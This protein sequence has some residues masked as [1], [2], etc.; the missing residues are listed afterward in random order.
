ML[1]KTARLRRLL[2]RVALLGLVLF[3]VALVLCWLFFDPLVRL[4]LVPATRD[5]NG[6]L[7]FDHASLGWGEAVLTNVRV[8]SEQDGRVLEAERLELGLHPFAYLFSGLDS[9]SMLGD[10]TLTRPV[11]TMRIDPDGNMNLTRLFVSHPGAK[12]WLARYQGTIRVLDGTAFYRDERRHLFVYKAGWQ[13]EL[14]VGPGPNAEVHMAVTPAQETPGSVKVSGWLGREVPAADVRFSLENIEL[15]PLAGFPPLQGVASFSGGTVS[16]DAW[17][18][19]RSNTFSALFRELAWGGTLRLQDGSLQATRLPW[20]I[21]SMEGTAQ[22]IGNAVHLEQLTGQA[23][24]MPFRLKGDAFFSPQLWLDLLAQFPRLQASRLKELTPRAPDVEGDLSLDLAVEG[25]P[26][27]PEVRGTVRSRELASQGHDLRD[28]TFTFRLVDQVLQVQDASA[29]SAGGRLSADGYVFLDQDAARS[30]MLLDLRGDGASLSQLSS[31]L[32]GRASFQAS[33]M[34]TLQDP[35]VNGQ[36]SLEGFSGLG[37]TVDSARAHFFYGGQMLMLRGAAVEQ[38]ATRLELPS[39]LLDMRDR[40]LTASVRAESMALPAFAWRGQPV[41]GSF[42]GRGLLW[43]LWDKPESLTA[44]GFFHDTSLAFSGLTA[45]DLAGE[46]LFSGHKVYLPGVTGSMQG[47]QVGLAGRY[48][49]NGRDSRLSLVGDNLPGRLLHEL[50]GVPVTFQG[51]IDTRVM[52]LDQGA[53]RFAGVVHGA[54]GSAAVQGTRDETGSLELVAYADHLQLQVL[55]LGSFRRVADDFSGRYGM[56]GPP[57]SFRYLVDGQLHGPR[58][59]TA[60]PVDVTAWGS[61]AG[62][63]LAV[64]QAVLS[65]DYPAARGLATT[66]VTGQAYPFPGPIF[67]PPLERVRLTQ[68]APP[69]WGLLT[70]GGRIDLAAHS[71]SLRYQARD[72]ELGWLASRPW[73]NDRSLSQSLGHQVAGGVAEGRGAITG[74]YHDPVVTAQVEVPWLSLAGAGAPLYSA[75]GQLTATRTALSLQPLW[76]SGQPFDPRLGKGPGPDILQVRGRVAYNAKSPSTL[77]LSTV[78]FDAPEAVALLPSS[79]SRPFAR[80]YGQVAFDNLRVTGPLARPSLAGELELRRGGIPLGDRIFPLDSLLVDFRSKAGDF[81]I[82]RLELLSGQLRLQGSGSR[83]AAGD[84]V[85]QLYSHD[86]PMTYFHNLGSP[87]TAL[88]GTA[89]LALQLQTRG[90]QPVAY[91]GLKAD[92]LSW[93]STALTGVAAPP[94]K[95]TRVQLGNF[96]ERP[97]GS[98]VTGPGQGIELAYNGT[99]ATVDIPPDGLSF[100]VGDATLGAQG[101]VSL[102]PPAANQTTA[103]WFR[104]PAGPDFGNHAGPFQARMENFAMSQLAGLLGLTNPDLEARLSGTLSLEGQWYRDLENLGVARLPRYGFEVRALEL[105]REVDNQRLAFQL[106]AP[107]TATFERQGQVASLSLSPTRLDGPT[108][109]LEAAGTL[110]LAGNQPSQ[111]TIQ[112]RD[113]PLESLAVL[114]PALMGLKGSLQQLDLKMSGLL[115]A[116]DLELSFQALRAPEKPGGAQLDLEGKISG[117]PQPNGGY[118]VDFGA[119]GVIMAIGSAAHVT[120]HLTVG[121][122][123]PLLWARETAA[124]PDRLN[125]VWEGLTV[126]SN[127]EMNL[128]ARIEDANMQLV[129]TLIPQVTS[130]SGRVAGSLDVTGTLEQPKVVGGLTVENGQMQTTFMKDPITNLNVVT[131]FEQISPDQAEQV[132]GSEQYENTFRSRYSI[133]RFEGMVGTHPFTVSGKAEMA[134]FA[135]TYL[136]L[137]LDGT[138]LPISQEKLQASADVAL[139]LDARPGR[140]KQNPNLHLLPVLTGQVNLPDGDVYLSLNDASSSQLK[141]PVPIRYDVA[142]T[143]GD[144]FWV[145]VGDSRV[146]AQGQLKL[147]PDPVT[148]SPV[149][150]G[151]A[152]LSR[153]VLQIPFYSVTFNIR[154][155]WAYWDRSLMPTLEN[156]EADTTIGTYQIVARVDGTYPDVKVELFSNPPLA[157]A[158]LVR[159]VAVSGLPGGGSDVGST[160][161]QMDNFLQS[162][163]LAVLSGLVANPITQQLSKVLFLSEVSFDYQ[164]PATYIVK[165]AKALDSH[166]RILLTL[167]RIIYGSGQSESLYGLEYRF[168]PNLLTRI[169]TDDLGQIR[170]WFQGIFSWW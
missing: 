41:T 162:Q 137:N 89:D 38:G 166:D 12:P 44:R 124:L 150:S 131:R 111:L 28:I 74:T 25:P 31:D 72:L 136:N 102:Q 32:Q 91:L 10:I 58:L 46:F 7:N 164:L 103:E 105:A 146:R 84:Y 143:L 51:P 96:Q 120:E 161:I 168:Q 73:F 88:D 8:D 52:F 151:S 134:G 152:F 94:M 126:R 159:L 154:Q 37:Q 13:G 101:A 56:Q 125:W 83:T 29:E 118:L 3:G 115:P 85:A 20:S 9:A 99:R 62:S 130:A 79:F 121:G 163:G 69:T 155:G 82:S 68:F 34:G 11:L 21:H 76:V 53:E 63:I 119:P 170:L 81:A 78:G 36:G 55:G 92:E 86:V 100:Q 33:V 40:F 15:K 54:E 22:L 70:A 106:A 145:H 19:G 45:A 147:Q 156:V 49:L 47:G 61:R 67:G 65:F 24:T 26:Q 23:D 132:A 157:Q 127:G 133:D 117:R 59:G 129:D 98:L 50:L 107:A 90:Q 64:D 43:G 1:G 165:L 60:G 30:S 169:S 35:L 142:L 5:L 122:Q 18:R 158:Q 42:S 128:S 113:L 116:P 80:V 57:N 71:L 108:G 6:R 17:T 123:I 14:K 109:F 138:G 149:L 4:A 39:V 77:A 75:R 140:T 148:H 95:L 97:D 16:G 93:S 27:H 160:N 48:D 112:A 167:T 114:D 104:S 87:F 153:G 110:V 2:P 144:N 66:G 141:F 135:P 139:T